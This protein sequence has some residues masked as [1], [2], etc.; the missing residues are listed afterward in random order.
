MKKPLKSILIVLVSITTLLG[1]CTPTSTTSVSIS[2]DGSGD[3]ATIEEAIEIIPPNSVILLGEGQ[4]KLS[5]PLVIEKS[6]TIQVLEL[7]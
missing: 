5:K 3:F 6:L 4:F 1:G 7:I 2:S